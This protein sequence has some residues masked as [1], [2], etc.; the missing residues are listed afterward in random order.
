MERI[1][2]KIFKKGL[3]LKI[4]H[5]TTMLFQQERL[6]E[7]T[8]QPQPVHCINAFYD[9]A[10]IVVT[11]SSSTALGVLMRTTCRLF[12]IVVNTPLGGLPVGAII[13]SSEE[14]DVLNAAF[15]AYK[16]LLPSKPFNNKE[17]PKVVISDDSKSL[18]NALKA[19]FPTATQLLCIFH[20]LWVCYTSIPF[21][22]IGNCRT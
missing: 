9:S 8:L 19:V 13:T 2:G 20:L 11:Y 17:E 22:L 3:C 15:S 10:L 21:T 5:L 18:K 1:S 7:T 6:G 4:N 12:Q 14:D 16:N